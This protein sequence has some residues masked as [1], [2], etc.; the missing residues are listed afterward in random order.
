[1]KCDDLLLATL[2]S[3]WTNTFNNWVLHYY[4]IHINMLDL[5]SG[6]SLS[7]HVVRLRKQVGPKL[8]HQRSLWLARSWTLN[9]RSSLPRS[10]RAGLIKPHQTGSLQPSMGRLIC[11][12]W[13]V[14]WRK[15]LTPS[16]VRMKR[17]E[18]PSWTGD[19]WWRSYWVDSLSTRLFASVLFLRWYWYLI[20]DLDTWYLTVYSCSYYFIYYILLYI[21]I[22]HEFLYLSLGLRAMGGWDMVGW[23]W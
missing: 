2:W 13:I 7:L 12:G 14:C 22:L 10:I 8:R 23:W 3:T 21:L 5:D 1:M 17:C 19:T 15:A 16:M 9:L 6:H 4:F 18:R 20:L 11:L